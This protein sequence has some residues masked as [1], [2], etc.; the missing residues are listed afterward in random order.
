[1]GKKTPFRGILTSFV[2]AMDAYSNQRQQI[3]DEYMSDPDVEQDQ[4]QRKQTISEWA[5][6]IFSQLNEL[7]INEICSSSLYKADIQDKLIKTEDPNVIL[8]ERCLIPGHFR[9]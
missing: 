7:V 6:A 9:N 1:M 8:G 5:G 4:N 3:I 2:K